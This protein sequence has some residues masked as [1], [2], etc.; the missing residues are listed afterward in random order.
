[1]D[2]GHPSPP[3]F[4][5]TRFGSSGERSERVFPRPHRSCTS[6][7]VY[8]QQLAVAESLA[9]ELPAMLHAITTAEIIDWIGWITAANCCN[10]RQIDFLFDFFSCPP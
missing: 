5:S 8:P 2:L 9:L 3:P 1:M 6:P 7:N 4:M 10:K